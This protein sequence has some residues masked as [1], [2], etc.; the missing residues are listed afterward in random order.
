[1][2]G[3]SATGT[4]TAMRVGAA[5]SA[6]ASP[7]SSSARPSA[8]RERAHRNGA[9]SSASS[10]ATRIDSSASAASA[11]GTGTSGSTPSRS[12]RAPGAGRGKRSPASSARTPISVSRTRAT[13]RSQRRPCRPSVSGGLPAP[14]PSEKRPPEARCKPGGGERDARRR[15]APHREHARAEPDPRRLRRDLGEHDRGVVAP[16]LRDLDAIEIERLGLLCEPHDRVH[17]RFEGGE[18]DAG[19]EIAIAAMVPPR[20]PPDNRDRTLNSGGQP[21]SNS[22]SPSPPSGAS[23]ASNVTSRTPRRRASVSRCAS[24][25]C[26]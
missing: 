12:G 13:G 6:R 9:H 21:V 26:R 19:R 24:V 2:S 16:R 7:S 11:I 15:P 8:S 5:R 20:A 4:A 25:T 23:P 14:N 3:P 22:T 17:A 1:M 10:P 18:R